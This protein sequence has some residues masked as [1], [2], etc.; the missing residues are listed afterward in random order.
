MGS[1]AQEQGLALHW[2]IE[3]SFIVNVG[4]QS[5]GA[6]DSKCLEV[7]ERVWRNS[8][9]LKFLIEVTRKS[10]ERGN[11]KEIVEVYIEELV[12]G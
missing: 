7:A 1:S 6:D 5:M 4:R 9:C 11:R 12:E 10:A 3:S 2:S 8:C